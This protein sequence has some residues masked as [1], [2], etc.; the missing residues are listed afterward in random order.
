[1]LIIM[2]QER[3]LLDIEQLNC[4][5]FHSHSLD[6]AGPL[7]P[8]SVSSFAPPQPLG[9]GELRRD[10]SQ[11]FFFILKKQQHVTASLSCW[12]LCNSPCASITE[13]CFCG[14]PPRHFCERGGGGG[15]GASFWFTVMLVFMVVCFSDA[16][17]RVEINNN[18]Q[19]FM[20]ASVG[21]IRSHRYYT[22]QK[23]LNKYKNIWQ[24]ISEL[25]KQG[26]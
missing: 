5:F 16:T 14:N 19:I 13:G 3:H 4:G 20:W 1:M 25:T 8:C 9:D 21:Q 17:Q 24:G 15:T 2:I 10:R 6:W 7:L 12:I 11:I 18:T 23:K 26:K 22:M